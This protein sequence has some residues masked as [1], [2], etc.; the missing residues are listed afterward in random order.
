MKRVLGLDVGAKR[1]GVALSD[2]LGITAQRLTL[3][4][5]RDVAQD[6]DVIASLV[7]KH[8]VATVVVGL[9]L[10]M[11]G[12]MGEQ[13][14]LVMAF[15][16]QLRARLSCSVEMVDERLTTVEGERALLSMDASRR[17]RKG[18]IDQVA[19]QLILQSYLNGR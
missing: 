19:A 6:L 7:A 15:V 2:A 1:I 17:T 14:R 12:E 9:P 10:T 13:A 16:E 18:L 8:D 4:E 11:K 3:I 5:R